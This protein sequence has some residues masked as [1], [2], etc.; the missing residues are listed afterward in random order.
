MK[1]EVENLIYLEELLKRYILIENLD[2][3]KKLYAEVSEY[4][5]LNQIIEIKKEIGSYY[6]IKLN[7][8]S[9]HLGK[10]FKNDKLNY[11]LC[12]SLDLEK[13]LIELNNLKKIK[14]M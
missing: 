11:F 4:A 13:P 10:Y 9:Y 1:I 3:I 12:H 6:L 2:V 5:K 7:N 14:R 8:K